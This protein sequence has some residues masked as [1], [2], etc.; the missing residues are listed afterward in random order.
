MSLFPTRPLEVVVDMHR[1]TTEFTL[2]QSERMHDSFAQLRA[3]V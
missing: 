1:S 2:G 3:G